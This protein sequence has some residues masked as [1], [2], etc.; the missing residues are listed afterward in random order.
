MWNRSSVFIASMVVLLNNTIF[1]I[2]NYI[3]SVMN[4]PN[5]ILDSISKLAHNYL[6]G[7]KSNNIG[8]YLVG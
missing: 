1:A 8:F 5:T 6:W 7:M 2:P 3:L 4:L